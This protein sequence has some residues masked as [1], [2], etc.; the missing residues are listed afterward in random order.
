MNMLYRT[1]NEG[2]S[3]PRFTLSLLSLGLLLGSAMPAAHAAKTE[4][5][6]T[7]VT[8]RDNAAYQADNAWVGGFE[9]TPLLDTPAAISGAVVSPAITGVTA[10]MLPALSVSVTL[11]VP[12]NVENAF[13]CVF[14]A[15]AEAVH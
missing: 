4:L 2:E 5:P 10:E 6:A 11:R 9:A 1:F 13:F 8:A 14:C 7:A 15:V 3:A 12:F